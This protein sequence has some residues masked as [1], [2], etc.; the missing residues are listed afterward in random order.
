[1]INFPVIEMSKTRARLER[2]DGR[3]YEY[4]QM[5]DAD[6]LDALIHAD[7]DKKL[8]QFADKWQPLFYYAGNEYIAFP[9]TSGEHGEFHGTTL[10]DYRDARALLVLA[11]NLRAFLDNDEYT[12]EN[13]E[14]IGLVFDH[15]EANDKKTGWY[16]DDDGLQLNHRRSLIGKNYFVYLDGA[17][18]DLNTP[19]NENELIGVSRWEKDMREWWNNTAPDHALKLST[20]EENDGIFYLAT[21]AFP[22]NRDGLRLLVEQALDELI[23]VHF[24]DIRTTTTN[25]GHEYRRCGSL[26]SS[27]W[28]CMVQSFEG[29]RTGRCEVCGKPFISKGE[30]GKPRKYCSSAC[31]KWAQRNPGKTR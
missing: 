4:H 3:L 17:S 7:T 9:P 28:Y 8:S 15:F 26:L 12:I 31:S 27:L 10:D 16:E 24:Y 20:E 13:L 6:T 2:L 23:T 11:M 18:G 21:I 14:H 29:G 5:P 22:N 1:M 30:R 25:G 19:L